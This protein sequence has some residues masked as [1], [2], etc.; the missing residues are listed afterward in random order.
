ME[1]PV[2]VEAR[3]PANREAELHRFIGHLWEEESR[4]TTSV[5]SNPGAAT[6][7]SKAEDLEALWT[8]EKVRELWKR[9]RGDN[10]RLFLLRQAEVAPNGLDKDALAREMGKTK[11]G[12]S[13]AGVSGA[14]GHSCGDMGVAFPWLWENDTYQMPLAIAALVRKVASGQ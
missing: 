4:P 13:V 10:S 2:T 14:V 6:T 3:V 9:C 1:Q 8:E 5:A 12:R 7:R 11:G